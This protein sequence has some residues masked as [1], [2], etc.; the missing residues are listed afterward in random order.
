MATIAEALDR[1][2]R[3]KF[4]AGFHLSRKD[5]AYLEEKGEDF[6]GFAF[7]KEGVN[8]F[9]D[10]M[11][12]PN[13]TQNK[14]GAEAFINFMLE[15]E[16]ALANAEYI[17]YASANTAVIENE[18]YSLSESEAVYPDEELIA[19]AQQFHDISNDNLQYM[20]T[21]WMKVKG[22][23]DSLGIYIAFF[24]CIIAIAVVIVITVI[25]KKKM[26]KYYNV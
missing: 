9:Y 5:L 25:K 6:L 16:V 22:S 19:N 1:L 20:S 17:Y 10:A 2:S 26:T 13:T 14:K 21:L 18:D 8:T 12:I 15:P 23:S 3:S 24:A 4:R 11:C 7:P